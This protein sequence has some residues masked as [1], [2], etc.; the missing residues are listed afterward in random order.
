MLIH[1]LLQYLIRLLIL[2]YILS[3]NLCAN[4]KV[5]P[6]MTFTK[7]TVILYGFRNYIKMINEQNW[8]HLW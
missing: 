1:C 6:S 5:L 3:L 8:P 7:L 2:Y 4:Q